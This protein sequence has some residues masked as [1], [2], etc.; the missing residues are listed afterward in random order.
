MTTR[1]NLI[2]KLSKSNESLLKQ[3]AVLENNN[4]LMSQRLDRMQDNTK[5]LDT[6]LNKEWY[7]YILYIVSYACTYE[8]ISFA[9]G[10]EITNRL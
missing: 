8:W 4:L 2:D 10:S 5:V 1:D 6:K 7:I 3:I 9:S